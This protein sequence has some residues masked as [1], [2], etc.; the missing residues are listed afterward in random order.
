[1]VLGL[2]DQI[3]TINYL[4]SETQREISLGAPST[5]AMELVDS[6]RSRTHS[7]ETV[8]AVG[9]WYRVGEKKI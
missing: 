2:P 9:K 1:V 8:T 4:R 5:M 6:L 3:V 7:N